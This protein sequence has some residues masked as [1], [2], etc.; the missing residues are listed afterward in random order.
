MHISK[1]VHRARMRRAAES[2]TTNT[3]SISIGGSVLISSVATLQSTLA[4]DT[5]DGSIPTVTYQFATS[6]TPTITSTVSVARS[7]SSSSS[8]ASTSPTVS[9]SAVSDESIPVG[10]VIGACVGAFAGLAFLVL[11]FYLCVK[12][13]IRRRAAKNGEKW[14]KLSEGADGSTH[15]AGEDSTRDPDEKNLRGMFKKPAPSIRTARTKLSDED[16]GGFG[17]PPLEFDKYRPGLAQEL[18]LH[19]PARPF[20][21]Q[22]A[23]RGES[24]S[25]W[26]GSTAREDSFLSMRSVRVDSPSL[27]R[28]KS[29]SAQSSFSPMHQWESAEVLTMD[30]EEVTGPEEV[31]DTNPFTDASEQRRSVANPFFKGQ[32]FRAEAASV[33]SRS[34]SSAT[35]MNQ[36]QSER[37][38][39]PFADIQEVPVYRVTPP[40]A[41]HLHSES[42][43]SGSSGG[44]FGE[45]ALKQ[46]IAALDL[47]QEEVEERLRA[48]SMHE[49]ELVE[50]PN[51]AE[52]DS[53]IVGEFPMPPQKVYT[54]P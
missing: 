18:A 27:I 50:E 33:L 42:V 21:G 31:R 2:D 1:P 19:S 45:H 14:N 23:Q 35:V 43:A 44:M 16:V 34:N 24:G 13:S 11:V 5:A 29:Q 9:A 20:A 25:S 7:T 32:D 3:G 41:V 12:R 26:D 52:P 28:A 15:S 30:E 53:A 46:L 8:S 37:M 51:S 47:S 36:R 49:G 17:L 10:A 38:S 39:N 22:V 54:A 40:A 6:G 4:L 48:V